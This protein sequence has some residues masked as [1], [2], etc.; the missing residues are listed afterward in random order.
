MLPRLLQKAEELILIRVLSRQSASG[1]ARR[2]PG[3]SADRGGR[4]LEFADQGLRVDES[5]A[6]DLPGS[7][8]QL[9]DTGV[10][11]AIVDAR[12]FPSG[13]EEAISFEDG[14]VLRG[15]ARVECEG[16]LKITDGSFAVAE[17][18]EDPY[19]YGMSEDPEEVR[20]ST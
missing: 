6:E 18:L 20:L 5:R 16:G 14:E 9:K 4:G 2:A 15:S 17:K 7:F 3:G 10:A 1:L 19:A 13:F 12:S 8:E 11:N